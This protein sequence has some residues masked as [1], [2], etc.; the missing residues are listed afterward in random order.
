MIFFALF[1]YDCLWFKS[2][3]MATAVV[4]GASGSVGGAL[5]A[6]LVAEPADKVARIVLLGRR[7]LPSS[8]SSSTSATTTATTTAGGAEDAASAAGALPASDPRVVQHVV[9]MDRLAEQAVRSARVRSHGGG[10]F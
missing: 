3:P 7:Q 5:L 2:P 8:A 4:L 1:P 10:L 6:S 9:D